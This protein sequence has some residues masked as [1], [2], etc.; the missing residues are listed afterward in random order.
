MKRS[1]MIDDLERVIN[2]L[3][4]NITSRELACAILNKVEEL[5]MG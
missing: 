3:P 4:D 1:E 5:G 2:C